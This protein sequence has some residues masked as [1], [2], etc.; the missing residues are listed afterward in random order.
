M[1]FINSCPCC[2]SSQLRK[3]P[4]IVAPFIARYACGSEPQACYLCECRSC[5]FRFFNSRLTDQEIGALYADYRGPAYFEA[6]H[7]HEFWYSASINAAIGNDP[8]EIE[9]RKL[10]LAKVLSARSESIV[11][12]LDYGGDRGQF[13]PD[14]LGAERYVYEI[15][16]ANPISGVIRLESVDGRQFD[17]VML[18]HVLEHCP[19]PTQFIQKL[20]PLANGHTVYYLEVP[21]E[22]PSLRFAPRGVMQQWYQ[23]FLLRVGPLLTAVDFYSTVCRVKFDC[24]LPFGIHKCS[25]HLNFFS[26]RSLRTLLERSGY[27]VLECGIA[28]TQALGP[29]S[30]ILYCLARVDGEEPL[31][32]E[33]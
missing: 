19:E 12:V 13:I 6:R 16:D 8:A 5:T 15:S 28:K 20:R 33:S 9:S 1:Y 29:S 24:N 14:H 23:D 17:L 25:E 26:E 11:S 18:A 27:E 4:A 2:A 3:W 30:R 21:F 7:R 10:H 22:R 32:R 31:R